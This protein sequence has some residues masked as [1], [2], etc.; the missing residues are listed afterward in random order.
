[1][2]GARRGLAF[3]AG[4]LLAA[5]SLSEAR[6]GPKAQRDLFGEDGLHDMYRDID[7]TVLLI[8]VEG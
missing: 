8:Y 1:M 3:A 2:G 4:V 7:A 6:R 5:S